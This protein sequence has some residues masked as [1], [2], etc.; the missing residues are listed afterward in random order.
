MRRNRKP[1]VVWL[2]PD[3]NNRVGTDL[4]NINPDSTSI[5]QTTITVANNYI[6]GESSG[7][8]IPLVA[9]LGEAE[10]YVPGT[11]A[12]GAPTLSDMYNSG[13][14]L[15]RICGHL[16]CGMVQNVG[17]QPGSG[18]TGN[19]MVTASF[20]VCRVDTSG[21]A[22][23]VQAQNPDT[24]VNQDN[25]W[26]W[27]RSWL[28]TNFV[29][30]DSQGGVAKLYLGETTNIGSSIREGSFV[31]QKTARI[32]GPDERLFM[33][34]VCTVLDGDGGSGLDNN[35][36]FNWNLRVLGSL[37]SNLGNRRNSSR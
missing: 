16:F 37:K 23:D 3:P 1:R 11:G 19:I 18:G 29:Y 28:L 22:V 5:G 6:P 9:D 15:R 31:D 12:P 4:V 2:P 26:I 34:L 17:I 7:K 21:L 13:Y 25:P 32:V 33:N 24:M 10:Q 20:Q 14:R 35:I 36:I 8:A 27:R 30:V